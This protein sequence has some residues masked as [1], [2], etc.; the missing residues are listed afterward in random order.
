M[1][2]KDVAR[3]DAVKSSD[4][5]EFAG[6]GAFVTVGIVVTKIVVFLIVAVPA[7]L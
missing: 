7:L 2:V 1:N 6:I 5:L 3:E 4:V